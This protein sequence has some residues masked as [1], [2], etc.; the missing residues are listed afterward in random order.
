MSDTLTEEYVKEEYPKIGSVVGYVRTD[1]K[2]E[3]EVGFGRVLAIC[4][5]EGKRLMVHLDPE[6]VEG[7]Q[8][9]NVDMSCLNPSPEFVEKF[10][11]AI[12]AVKEISEEGNAKVQALVTIYNDRVDFVRNEI[13]GSPVDF[14]PFLIGHRKAQ[15]EAAEAAA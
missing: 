15:E 10:T 6:A 2:G 9:F 11:L 3:T 5:D 4:M 8:K 7:G 12:D 14:D 1:Q 13:F